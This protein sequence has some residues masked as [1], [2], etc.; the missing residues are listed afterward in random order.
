MMVHAM[1]RNE[2]RNRRRILLPRQGGCDDST[3]AVVHDLNQ[4][5]YHPDETN[6]MGRFFVIS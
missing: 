4:L 6:D 1:L 3:V 5:P 2:I